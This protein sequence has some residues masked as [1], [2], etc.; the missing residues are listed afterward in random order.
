MALVRLPAKD[1][2]TVARDIPG[3][4][5][6]LFPQLIPGVVAH[7]NRKAIVIPECSR[8]PDA[9]VAAS[10]LN[11]AMLFELAFSRAEQLLNDGSLPDWHACLVVAVA[12]QRRHFDAKLPTD[13][14]EADRLVAEMVAENLVRML[15]VI[16]AR[17]PAASLVSSPAIPGYQWIASGN[18]DFSIDDALIE[19]KCTNRHFSSSDYRQIVMYWLLSYASSIEGKS[20]E[21]REIYLVNPRL[22]YIVN[23]PF[24]LLVSTIS[25]GRSKLDLLE[26]LA[27]M[28]GEHTL[29]M[30]GSTTA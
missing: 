23:L 5:D 26:L 17:Y 19:F 7:F 14:C 27:S 30:L 10:A 20:E 13:I 6:A 29:R 11:K 4:F 18:G 12:R 25:G 1:P 24:A 28:V 22:N 2:R 16:K 3:I 9:L 8:V 21:W 15:E